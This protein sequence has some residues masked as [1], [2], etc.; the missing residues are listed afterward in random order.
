MDVREKIHKV[1]NKEFKHHLVQK[2][3]A[4]QRKAKLEREEH[5]RVEVRQA[6]VEAKKISADTDNEEYKKR[7]GLQ[8]AQAQVNFFSHCFQCFF[9]ALNLICHP[10]E[11]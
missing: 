6:I 3:K 9:G 4:D 5:L 10:D 1:I 8:I 7:R 11:S 2:H